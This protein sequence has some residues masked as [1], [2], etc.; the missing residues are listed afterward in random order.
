MG[1]EVRL[2][3]LKTQFFELRMGCRGRDLQVMQ[4]SFAI[5]F[6]F[7]AFL[8]N[9]A[10]L[11][12][13]SLF[14]AVLQLFGGALVSAIMSRVVANEAF[15]LEIDEH[16]IP[17]IGFVLGRGGQREETTV[18][19]TDRPF[20][21]PGMAGHFDDEFAFR[22]VGGLFGAHEAFEESVV[23]R[24]IFGRKDPEFAAEA[25]SEGVLRDLF[26]ASDTGGAAALL[27]VGPIGL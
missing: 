3:G 11:R 9:K 14:S 12:F 27:S 1:F 17:A 15:Q 8:R 7:G 22:F 23:S 20:G 5:F 18:L 26:A 19:A 16:G 2:R 24:L 13:E 6:G 4:L 25:V 10:I 21:E